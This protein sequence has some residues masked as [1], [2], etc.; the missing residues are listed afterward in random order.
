MMMVVVKMSMREKT[1]N[2]ARLHTH[3]YIETHAQEEDDFFL[4]HTF[5][6][7]S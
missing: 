3:V 7:V 6:P 2:G 1:T 4:L 5:L